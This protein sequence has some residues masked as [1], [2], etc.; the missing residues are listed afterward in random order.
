MNQTLAAREWFLLVLL[1]VLW[2]GSFFFVR[3]ALTDL[4]PFT[5]VF[6][7]VGIAAL[8]LLAYVY[9]TGQRMPRSRGLWIAF[10]V[11]GFLNGLLPYSL[12]VW[13]QQHIDSGLAAILNGTTPL[14]SVIL[15]PILA[16]EE[17]LTLS[18]LSGVVIGFCGVVVLIGPE[19]LH[20]LG[21]HGLGQLAVVGA[22][23][24]YA[25]AAIYWRQFKGIQPAVAAT[26]QITCTAIFVLPLALIFDDPWSLSPSAVTWGAI[27]GLSILSTAIAYLIY[28]R[29]LA[30]AG[31]TNV[32][33][34][35]FLIPVSALLL[36]IFLLGEQPDWTVFAGM[37][38]IFTGIAAVDGRVLLHLRRR[39]A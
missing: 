27:L 36:G 8:A 24:S 4:P 39:L 19:A 2:G 29:I 38:L 22:A 35:T 32:L 37:A 23:V 17:R 26:G 7:R 30:S 14:F 12:I 13:G 10:L 21:V 11:M 31:A 34:V 15:A 16:G 28:F 1:S 33:L 18:R 6:G 9:L 25:C 5:V 3:V 20:G